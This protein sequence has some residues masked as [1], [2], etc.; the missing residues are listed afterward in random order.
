MSK[1]TMLVG[2]AGCGKST[3]A[4]YLCDNNNNYIVVS[5]D[6]IRGELYG[7]ESIQK[8]P[9]EIFSVCRTRCIE[10]L[11]AGKDVIL[12]ATN[13]NRKKRKA[14]LNDLK[15]RVGADLLCYCVVIAI[16]YEDC[17]A[18]NNS[19]DRKVPEK[20]IRKHFCQFQMPLYSE[21]WTNISVVPNST[22]TLQEMLE[23]C[24]AIEHDNHH[25]KYNVYGHVVKAESWIIDHVSDDDPDR[26][27]LQQ[28]ALWHDV[29]KI[30][31]KVFSDK[32]G[33]A[34]PEAHFYCHE[35]WSTMYCLCAPL[36]VGDLKVKLAQLVSLHMMKY[37]P[38]YN[39]FIDR[40][41]PEHRRLLEIFNQADAES[42]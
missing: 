38:E 18:Q 19:R 32:K 35:C 26:Y 28:L 41:A 34:T 37:Q 2:P 1:F 8:D 36:Y 9:A 15:N 39:V 7:D 31:T 42:A 25:H 27:L 6:S 24:K 11:N 30:Y 16:T 21:G 12:D 20:V 14:F 29:G 23:K 40:W 13:L 17:L 3:C 10:F 33:N 22:V 4:K 5:S